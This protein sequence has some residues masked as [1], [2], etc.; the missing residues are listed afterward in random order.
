MKLRYPLSLLLGLLIL[1][2]TAVAQ[3]ACCDDT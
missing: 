1:A 2:T 3:T